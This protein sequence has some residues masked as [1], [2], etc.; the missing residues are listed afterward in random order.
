VSWDELPE[1]HG[2]QQIDQRWAALSKLTEETREAGGVASAAPSSGT[3]R[4]EE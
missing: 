3:P 4:Q 1:G 2:H